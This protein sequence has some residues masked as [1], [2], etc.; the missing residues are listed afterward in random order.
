[1]KH[2]TVKQEVAGLN[3]GRDTKGFTFFLGY[4]QSNLVI[5]IYKIKLGY[6]HFF[7]H[8]FQFIILLSP[9]YPMLYTS[10][11]Y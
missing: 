4:P 8:P 1:M 3:V 5:V 7:S 2:R 10:V 9:K 11:S 6:D